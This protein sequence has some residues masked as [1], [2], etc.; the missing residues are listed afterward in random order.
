MGREMLTWSTELNENEM[1]SL[2]N[3]EL[4]TKTLHANK[5]KDTANNCKN[6]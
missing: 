1:P 3:Y 5:S 4:R 2:R 6:F